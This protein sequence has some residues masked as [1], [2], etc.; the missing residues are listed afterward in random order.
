MA[1]KACQKALL[2]LEG[3]L[4]D[5]TYGA[6]GAPESKDEGNLERTKWTALE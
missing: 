2:H 1:L 3:E 5:G 6:L 4:E